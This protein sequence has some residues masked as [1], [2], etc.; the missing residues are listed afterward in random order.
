MSDTEP[1]AFRNRW[2]MSAAETYEKAGVEVIPLTDVIGAEIRGLD[3][4]SELAPAA[5]AAVHRAWLEHCVVLMRDQR[6]GDADLIRFSRGFG[7]LDRGP[8]MARPADRDAHPEIFVVSNVLENGKPIG[9]LDDRPLPW[10]TD[11]SHTEAPPKASTLHALEAPEDGSGDTGFINMYEVLDSLP[12]DLKGRIGPLRLKHDPAYALQGEVRHGFD[13]AG[14]ER[15]E[16]AP[17]PVHPL[18]RTHP[19]TGRRALYLGRHWNGDKRAAY[20]VGMS[21][22]ESDA[23]LDALWRFVAEERPVWRHQWRAGDYVMWDNR[24]VMHQRGSL[25]PARRR[26]MH[27]T[28]IKDT[29]RPT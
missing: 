6:L 14:H 10:H 9:F 18:V 26:V 1:G 25:D 28:Q 20:V 16:S 17:G 5:R 12:A 23:L 7:E 4:R 29:A 11:M 24:C 19:E 13:A 27:R 2:P 8:P 21:R 15:I 3:L 22:V